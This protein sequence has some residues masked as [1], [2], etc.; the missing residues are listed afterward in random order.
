MEENNNELA[1]EMPALKSD[2]QPVAPTYQNTNAEVSTPI[3]SEQTQEA[4][5]I[6]P[7]VPEIAPIPAAPV[8]SSA[9]SFSAPVVENTA[10][11]MPSVSAEP[12]IPV[13]VQEPIINEPVITQ[14]P[15]MPSTETVPMEPVIAPI[16]ET[17][18]T[19]VS[20]V[21][22]VQNTP[23]QNDSAPQ[24]AIEPTLVTPTPVVT[25]GVSMA[26]VQEQSVTVSE[27]VKE[28]EIKKA[29]KTSQIIGTVVLLIIT[30]LIVFWLARRY[31]VL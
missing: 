23:I 7:V 18:V 4:I 6:A 9:E 19:P 5:P 24:P 27:K 3:L 22:P 25:P 20:E 2:H 11:E 1:I 15:I 28:P 17:T 29:S 31:F 26:P 12:V 16:A 30:A 14:E 8:T 21:T 13:S 10:I